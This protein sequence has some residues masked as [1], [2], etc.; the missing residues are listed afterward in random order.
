[1]SNKVKIKRAKRNKKKT[2]LKEKAL[3]GLGLGSMFVG[4]AAGMSRGMQRQRMVSTIKRSW[5]DAL[6]KQKGESLGGKIKKLFAARTAKA[7]GYFDVYLFGATGVYASY[8][9]DGQ[10]KAGMMYRVNGSF[11]WEDGT[12]VNLPSALSADFESGTV[13]ASDVGNALPPAIQ[14][15]LSGGGGQT[16]PP[17]ISLQIIAGQLPDSFSLQDAEQFLVLEGANNTLN[18][19]NGRPAPGLLIQDNYYEL[20]NN[21][22]EKVASGSQ[23]RSLIISGGI[24]AGTIIILKQL[25]FS[26]A[27]YG[28]P[29][30]TIGGKVVDAAQALIGR[31]V[32]VF[33]PAS[34][35]GGAAGAAGATGT[36]AT[37]LTEVGTFPSMVTTP[38]GA[39]MSQ[40]LAMS[41]AQD[42]ILG[43]T[44]GLYT[45]PEGTVNFGW[46]VDS[47][48]SGDT[49]NYG[50]EAG[51]GAGLGA[52]AIEGATATAVAPQGPF[53]QSSI[54]YNL[55]V[56]AGM[57]RTPAGQLI[58][59]QELKEAW[60]SS[61]TQ[62]LLDW[63]LDDPNATL[64]TSTNA[65]L[66]P[67]Q[68]ISFSEP[69]S[70]LGSTFG[71]K[72]GISF[73]TATLSAGVA[74]AAATG[75]TLA[76][77]TTAAITTTITFAGGPPIALGTAY[78]ALGTAG[79]AATAGAG[80]AAA[81]GAAG[82]GGIGGALSG[83]AGAVGGAI[84]SAGSAVGAAL[85]IGAVAGTATVVG[86]IVVG[87]IYGI[88]AIVNAIGPDPRQVP[89]TK[90]TEQI[91]PSI[92][93]LVDG[94]NTE[95]GRSIEEEAAKYQAAVNAI[96]QLKNVLTR[97]LQLPSSVRSQVGY[98]D[99]FINTMQQTYDQRIRDFRAG[100]A[101]IDV[102][103]YI[104]T[105]NREAYIDV[106][107][108]VVLDSNGVVLSHEGPYPPTPSIVQA[109]LNPA[110]GVIGI[111]A[112]SQEPTNE[113]IP[114]SDVGPP[115][116]SSQFLPTPPVV[117][118]VF[119]TNEGKV[120]WVAEFDLVIIAPDGVYRADPNTGAK[121]NQRI[122]N[123]PQSILD[124]VNGPGN[125]LTDLRT[126][127]AG[128]PPPSV[129]PPPA[130][131][132]A[133]LTFKNAATGGIYLINTS[134]PIVVGVGQ[135]WEIRIQGP[136]GAQVTA[137]GGK[138]AGTVFP[139]DTTS[140]G[141]I[142][143]SGAMVLS[144][145]FTQTD[146]GEW[147]LEWKVNN[148][149]IGFI[150]FS[151][152]DVNF[153]PPPVYAPPS[154]VFSG[155]GI[156]APGVSQV[157][158][159]AVVTPRFP[160]AD[161]TPAAQTVDNRYGIPKQ[162]Q[163]YVFKRIKN[164]KN[165]ASFKEWANSKTRKKYYVISGK[166]PRTGEKFKYR[167]TKQQA[168]NIIIELTRLPL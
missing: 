125:N 5:Q 78:T 163:E 97:N 155:A 136:A 103:E 53:I 111:N 82:T 58:T 118:D 120:V 138:R 130:A 139:A 112:A 40:E 107:G 39:V 146:I 149:S 128:N 33:T 87:A 108:M 20:K 101:Q 158:P 22:Y 23:V 14:A 91:M 100:L 50:W 142:P 129:S 88:K 28:S 57:V 116:G 102:Y 71:L 131:I 109:M 85:G 13:V 140:Y 135:T 45:T 70:V 154:P 153:N 27:S 68:V 106:F 133:V 165:Y 76:G 79:G 32:G 52:G 36:A 15:L 35:T 84:S 83:V 148:Q 48:V 60:E 110:K 12:P 105:G 1:M 69:D 98:I 113:N 30:I 144:G 73:S 3:A 21:Q 161:I 38:T 7:A 75:A 62:Q 86:G 77:P 96:N 55:N 31:I 124:A 72:E 41:I 64:T 162:L 42:P 44:F 119:L 141:S 123:F 63:G 132:N 66:T 47:S 4:G 145:A 29:L 166:N 168:K 147:R 99:G 24:V 34:A 9:D 94:Y 167:V 92:T 65:Q 114:G 122:S 93:R 95:R 104:E 157:V 59:P 127:P 46:P 74:A 126:P 81:G 8:Y 37:T 152:Q 121:T 115:A 54:S 137:T 51:I 25:N 43:P 134:Q 10:G 11:Y 17:A 160:P 150:H 2:I 117:Y 16:P 159:S 49:V 156:I 67:D 6:K 56:P 151:L 89:D 90:V 19:N 18:T 80:G 164:S 143:A 26:V 61:N